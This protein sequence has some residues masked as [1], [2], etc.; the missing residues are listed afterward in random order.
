MP[1]LQKLEARTHFFESSNQDYSVNTRPYCRFRTCFNVLNAPGLAE[2]DRQ[3]EWSID[4]EAH[5]RFPWG[6]SR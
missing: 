5:K 4:C 1:T 3:E 6:M 2:V